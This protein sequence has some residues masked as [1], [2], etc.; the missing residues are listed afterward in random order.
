MTTFFCLTAPVLSLLPPLHVGR[1]VAR[2]DVPAGVLSIP[3]ALYSEVQSC[4]PRPAFVHRHRLAAEPVAMASSSL[5]L[6]SGK[7]R[8]IDSSAAGILTSSFAAVERLTRKLKSFRFSRVLISVFF[9]GVAC[10]VA[11]SIV[12]PVAQAPWHV[13]AS[14]VNAW[15]WGSSLVLLVISLA[16]LAALRMLLPVTARLY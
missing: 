10:G 7:S 13:R 5:Y 9:L 6:A 3:R 11:S 4:S 8:L 14:V 12:A 1:I 2:G 16:K 15:N